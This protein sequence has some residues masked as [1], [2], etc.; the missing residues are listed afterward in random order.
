MEEC[1]ELQTQVK[2]TI[3]RV[4]RKLEQK[5]SRDSKENP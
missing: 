1:I 5:L 2:K 3:R 4:K